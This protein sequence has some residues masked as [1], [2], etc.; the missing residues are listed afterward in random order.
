MYA[1]IICEVLGLTHGLGNGLS[2]RVVRVVQAAGY[3][4]RSCR[5]PSLLTFERRDLCLFDLLAALDETVV[6]GTGAPVDLIDGPWHGGG[7]HK[8]A[9]TFRLVARHRF[10]ERIPG[11]CEFV[12]RLPVEVVYFR[13]ER[14]HRDII[15]STA[16]GAQGMRHALSA[17]SFQ[18]SAPASGISSS[19]QLSKAD[20]KG[21]TVPLKSLLIAGGVAVVLTIALPLRSHAQIPQ[22]S[23]PPATSAPTSSRPPTGTATGT[24]DRQGQ[25]G[26]I[27]SG[28]PPTSTPQQSP[29]PAA[30][31]DEPAPPN[32]ARSQ[33][34]DTNQTRDRNQTREQN[35]NR[36]RSF[37]TVV[38]RALGIR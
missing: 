21:G 27:A 25:A 23:Q 32:S 16:V 11:G 19:C 12:E 24:T 22:T 29:A 30:N 17:I 1:G 2:M 7:L 13:V 33:D 35:P 26:P 37:F 20:H 38:A 15:T 6:R 10:R 9:D 4:R 18:L 5:V 31:P 36:A 3:R 34:R 8:R 28:P 14:G